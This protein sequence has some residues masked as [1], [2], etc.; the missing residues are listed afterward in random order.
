M[1]L[2][3][4]GAAMIVKDADAPEKLL[5]TALDVLGKPEEIQK[6]EKNAAA[7]GLP[8]AAETIAKEAYKLLE[9]KND[10]QVR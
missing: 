5:P 4:K 10:G 6:M 7:L 9:E 8:D 3:N 1:A 2:V